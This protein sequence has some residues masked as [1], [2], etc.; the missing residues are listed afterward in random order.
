M[1]AEDVVGPWVLERTGSAKEA[2]GKP[3]RWS[4][5]RPESAMLELRAD[6]SYGRAFHGRPHQGS[7]S[8]ADGALVLVREHFDPQRATLDG[9][10][11]E[12][13]EADEEHGG[14]SVLQFSRPKAAAAADDVIARVNKTRDPK[15]LI[16]KEGLIERALREGHA[17]LLEL[18]LS[19]GAPVYPV[20]LNRLRETPADALPALVRA[21][22]A[23]PAVVRMIAQYLA[24]EAP[25]AV[26]TAFVS[27]G[28][29]A[30]TRG[31]ALLAMFAGSYVRIDR[32]DVLAA[33][34][35]NDLDLRDGRGIPLRI[36]AITTAPADWMALVKS[37]PDVPLTEPARLV[38]DSGAIELPSGT[39]AAGAAQLALASLQAQIVAQ[40]SIAP[41]LAAD[42][43]RIRAA[44][45][46]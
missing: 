7:W 3:G 1:R 34:V 44:L 23:S 4:K 36:H 40:P 14:W 33:L 16:E 45:A 32:K 30:A 2:G 20:S 11:L 31:A 28:L 42:C 8:I 41:R 39:T 6:G 37:A 21:L 43:E 24:D 46:V 13:R 15:K 5:A 22:L 27:A 9:D 18:C 38:L 17:P 35:T 25:P 19:K 26:A 29:D 10:R 12:L